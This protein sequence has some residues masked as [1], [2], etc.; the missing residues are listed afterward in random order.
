M[1]RVSVQALQELITEVATEEN[2]SGI[3]ERIGSGGTPQKTLE[4]RILMM[5]WYM[6]SL[7]KF[8]SLADRFGMAESTACR[9]LHDML[10]FIH[11]YL[12]DRVIVWP[13]PQE[14]TEIKD[15]Y[16][17]LKNFTGVVGMID[18]SHI[19]IHQ[20]SERGYDYYNRNSYYSIVLQAVVREDRRFTH[21]YT[22]WPGKV[23]DARIFRN[24]PL[25]D[26]GANLCGDGHLLGDSAYPNLP[27]LLTPYRDNGHLTPTQKRYNSVHSAIRVTVENAFG[28]LKGR[29]VRLKYINQKKIETIVSTIVTAC[30]LHNIC[31]LNNEGFDD[32]LHEENVPQP[33]PNL[34]NFNANAQEQA[35]VKRLTIARRL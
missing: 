27:F 30:V 8:S 26:H 24:S 10:H 23:H 28:I 7:D 6:A 21:I 35:A 9:A 22:G 34:Q 1:G 17:E 4:E 33:R 3:T 2:I 14:M 25:Y 5:L 12:L 15:M 19:Q 32:L 11:Q 16:F 31:I 13:S 29:F 20:P 18:G